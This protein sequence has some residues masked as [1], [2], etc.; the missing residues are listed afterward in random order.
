MKT[1]GLLILLFLYPLYAHAN[2][3]DGG[4]AYINGDFETAAEI[5]KDLAKRGDH[6]AMYALGSMYTAGHGVEKDLKRAHELFSEAAQNGRADAMYKLGLMY[7]HGNGIKK[8]TKKAIRLYRKS[9]QKGYALSQYRF[10][11]MY[12]NGIEV[13]Q[14]PVNAYAWLVVAA[15]QFIYQYAG[16]E[17]TDTNNSVKSKKY[18]L[19]LIQKKEKERLLSE[20]TRHLQALRPEMSASDIEKTY[21]KVKK[22][23]QYRWKHVPVR[24]KNVQLTPDI[25]NLFLP[26][27]LQ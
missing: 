14:N 2:F 11:L 23:S 22:Y 4:D 16:D 12:L 21:K 1:V 27:T 19:L 20:I 17:H 26:E 7:E 9:A 8:S 5:F 10:G 13:K 15:H 3:K 6:R 25:E 18:L 24:F